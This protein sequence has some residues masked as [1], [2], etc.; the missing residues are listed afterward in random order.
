MSL[1]ELVTGSDACTPSDGGA[2]PSN[3]LSSFTNAFLGSGSKTQEQ[4]REV[5]ALLST[6]KGSLLAT[7]ICGA[8]KHGLHRYI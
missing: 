3:A 2:G 6:V 4:L 8:S 1:R 5:R 7:G